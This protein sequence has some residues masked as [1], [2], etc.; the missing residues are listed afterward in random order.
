MT[1][2]ETKQFNCRRI[3]FKGHGHCP[4]SVIKKLYEFRNNP[5]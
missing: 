1:N 2:A 4:I 5:E 3:E